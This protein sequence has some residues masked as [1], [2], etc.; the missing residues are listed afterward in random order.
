MSGGPKAL[1]IP[2]WGNAPGNRRPTNVRAESPIH[3]ADGIQR[4][5]GLSALWL[6]WAH[7]LGRCPISANLFPIISNSK[8]SGI[9][10][11]SASDDITEN[12]ARRGDEFIDQALQR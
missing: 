11:P 3:A 8:T 5:G 6:R 9:L 1:P 12:A 7:F 4:W 10:H 2:A